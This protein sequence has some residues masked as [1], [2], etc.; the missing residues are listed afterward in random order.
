MTAE[1]STL[2]AVTIAA[3]LNKDVILAQQAEIRR[4]KALLAIAKA[5]AKK[6]KGKKR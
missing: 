3:N 4:L 2:E 1:L 6:A 5:K